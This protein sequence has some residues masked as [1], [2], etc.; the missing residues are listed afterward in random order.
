MRGTIAGRRGT[1]RSALVVVHHSSC[2]SEGAR[3]LISR[4]QAY[5]QGA[6]STGCSDEVLAGGRSW[7]VFTRWRGGKRRAVKTKLISNRMHLEGEG[8]N[9]NIYSMVF[10]RSDHMRRATRR[11]RT[12]S[13]VS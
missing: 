7:G 12:C 8:G 4:C 1:R 2:K 10:V 5:L 6:R 3:A 11:L 13:R 9:R